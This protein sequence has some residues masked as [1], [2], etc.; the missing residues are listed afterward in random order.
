[1]LKNHKP[2]LAVC[3]FFNSPGG[4]REGK[5]CRW[6]HIEG[7]APAQLQDSHLKLVPCKFFYS[8]SGCIK[9]DTCPYSH[10]LKV[11]LSS[12]SSSI[13]TSKSTT[14]DVTSDK[15]KE[16]IGSTP[17]CSI[18]LEVVVHPNQ[19]GL[20]NKC[21]HC[22]CLN[23]IRQWRQNKNE[24]KNHLT[25]PMCR[26][27]SDY[28]TPSMVFATGELKEQIST[29]YLKHL[30]TIPCKKFEYGEGAC[31]FGTNC[32]YAHLLRDGSESSD[33]HGK[34]YKPKR[35]TCPVMALRHILNRMRYEEL[36]ELLQEN[37]DEHVDFLLDSLA[38]GEDSEDDSDNSELG[39]E[40]EDEE[41]EEDTEAE[42]R[43]ALVLRSHMRHSEPVLQYEDDDSD[44]D[45]PE[46][47][48]RNLAATYEFD[49][50]AM[51]PISSDDDDNF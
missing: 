12:S 18:C 13:S 15:S 48:Y 32:F 24:S 50:R 25:C 27:R 49:Y 6:L 20:L 29:N 22:F 45:G 23:C 4:C 30:K 41:A 17:D 44:Y 40:D 19:F 2:N 46:D 51:Y 1:M 8:S 34:A 14:S 28:V 5:N 21:D 16:E 35:D 10:D 7:E 36:M 33:P 43:E 39:E 31:S 37:S 47:Y 9:G 26:A 3:R 11:P 42:S 38:R